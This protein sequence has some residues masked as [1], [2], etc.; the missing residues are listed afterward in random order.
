MIAVFPMEEIG[1]WSISTLSQSL[2]MKFYT[3]GIDYNIQ[4]CGIPSKR[5]SCRS[6]LLNKHSSLSMYNDLDLISRSCSS[7]FLFLSKACFAPSEFSNQ[8]KDNN[9]ILAIPQLLSYCTFACKYNI[10]LNLSSKKSI[11]ARCSQLMM[12]YFYI[13]HSYNVTSN[14][15]AFNI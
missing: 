4:R 7:L 3:N 8:N 12:I 9:M 11:I 13:T 1:S 2:Q 5:T 10:T 6:F 15:R 14:I